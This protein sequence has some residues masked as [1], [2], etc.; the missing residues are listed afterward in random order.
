V[1]D[2]LN[3]SIRK[4]R[5]AVIRC[6]DILIDRGAIPSRE[7]LVEMCDASR[8]VFNS[9]NLHDEIAGAAKAASDALADA[10][11]AHLMVAEA[12]AKRMVAGKQ[13]QQPI[14]QAWVEAQ[15]EELAAQKERQK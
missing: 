7:T 1:S 8:G 4:A 3:I 11:A 5:T 6:V 15:A 14:S 9:E 2:N 13:K 10:I 12:R